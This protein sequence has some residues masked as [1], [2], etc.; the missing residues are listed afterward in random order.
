MGNVTVWGR[1][2]DH[3]FLRFSIIFGEI[4]FVFLKNRCY[5]LFF[6]KLAVVEA[7]NANIFAKF[8]GGNIFR[9]ITSVPGVKITSYLQLQRQPWYWARAFF[10]LG[11]MI[12]IRKTRYTLC[13]TVL[14][15][16]RWK[17]R[18]SKLQIHPWSVYPCISVYYFST[19]FSIL[20]GY[21]DDTI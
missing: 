1:C 13:Y 18:N 19:A 2:Y 20:K 4:F 21:I 9:I 8:L 15:R 16:W 14:Q 10:K 11:K 17:S 3:N 5:D 7:K 6:Q 12:F